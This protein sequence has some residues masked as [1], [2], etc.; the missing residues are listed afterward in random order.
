MVDRRP[1]TTSTNQRCGVTES[2]LS[3]VTKILERL[4]P[5]YDV[6]AFGSRVSGKAVKSSDL[7]IVIMT[8]KPLSAMRLIGLKSEFVGSDLPFK[9]DITDWA[10]TKDNFRA[11]IESCRAIIQ[12]GRPL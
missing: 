6:Y 1:E 2:E 10:S 7:D 3:I 11:V 8:D 5:E 12:T 4:V 9:V